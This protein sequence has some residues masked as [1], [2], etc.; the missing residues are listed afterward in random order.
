[1][2]ASKNGEV[3][4][5]FKATVLKTVDLQGSVSS[6]LTLSATRS[7]YRAT[8][9]LQGIVSTQSGPKESFFVIKNPQ[10]R[11]LRIF[12]FFCD[13][14]EHGLRFAIVDVHQA[15]EC[16]RRKIFRCLDHDYIANFEMVWR[17]DAR[18]RAIR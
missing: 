7:S 18:A 6:N 3:A 8:R 13:V 5:W 14:F 1:M 12:E 17:E 9:M 15:I 16:E 10:L 4:E 2:S 11:I